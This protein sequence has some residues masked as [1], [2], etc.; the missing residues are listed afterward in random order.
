MWEYK[1]NMARAIFNGGVGF[2]NSKGQQVIPPLYFEVRDYSE[3]LA[4][5]QVIN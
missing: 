2:I 5:V 1:D 4:R 3:G